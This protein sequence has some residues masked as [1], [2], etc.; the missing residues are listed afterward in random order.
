[1]GLVGVSQAEGAPTRDGP[2]ADS[3]RTKMLI[4]DIL[5]GVGIAA[6]GI[7]VV[8]LVLQGGKEEPAKT[9]GAGAASRVSPFITGRGGGV[10]VQF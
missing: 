9:G 10:R 5:G 2:E 7:G 1:V 4:G 6:A 3:A 8:V